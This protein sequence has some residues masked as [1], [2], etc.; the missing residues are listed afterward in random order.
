M[1]DEYGP[2]HGDTPAAAI[3]ALVGEI[4]P[5]ERSFPTCTC[6]YCANL[7]PRDEHYARLGFD[8]WVIPFESAPDDMEMMALPGSWRFCPCC[9]MRLRKPVDEQVMDGDE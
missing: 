9:G 3:E 8:E 5:P 4:G 2:V 7:G 1:H 6:G